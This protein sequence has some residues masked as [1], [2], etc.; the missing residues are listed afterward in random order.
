MLKKSTSGWQLLAELRDNEVKPTAHIDV[1]VSATISSN[2]RETF[3]E[4][5]WPVATDATFGIYR[6]DVV[7]FDSK[8]FAITT[9]MTPEMALLEEN[10]TASDVYNLVV[11]TRDEVHHLE[12]DTDHLEGGLGDLEERL[13][14]LSEHVHGQGGEVSQFGDDVDAI[15]QILDSVTVDFALLKGDV[16]S[17]RRENDLVIE[18]TKN[19]NTSLARNVESVK[20]KV[21]SIA[22]DQVESVSKIEDDMNE[23]TRKFDGLTKDVETLKEKVDS[24]A[25]LFSKPFWPEG[26][27]ALLQPK[28]G[29]PVG[30]TFLGVGDKYWQIHT[31]SSSGSATKN[32]FSD[33]LPPNTVS[34]VNRNNFLTLR[35]CESNIS[36][37]KRSWPSGSYCINKIEGF[38]CPAGLNQGYVHFDEEGTKHVRASKMNHYFYF[39]C[40]TS[41]Y[42]S[43]AITLPTHSPFLLYR[44]GGQCQQVSGMN[45]SEETVTVDTEKSNNDD[46][47][48]GS[49]P[50]VD[51]HL[52][53]HT[54][55]T[56][57]LCYYTLA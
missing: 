14:N 6:C 26:K 57:H 4:I 52:Y 23:N 1:S 3:L 20:E 13:T 25:I 21:D 39:C 2:I 55:V 19:I 56:L 16:A 37:S 10:L 44:R 8:N 5:I 17:L 35:F 29:C 53:G 54:V 27:F 47:E 48:S 46:G 33:A 38:N 12:N 45:V 22:A 18:N 30:L 31:E 15:R 36:F 49:V 28:D 51:I 7:G 9:E 41:G 40:M 32:A 11:E 34:K 50:D 43:N 24:I 42:S